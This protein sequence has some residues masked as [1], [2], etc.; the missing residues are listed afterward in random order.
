MIVA[1][2]EES[3]SNMKAIPMN[4]E[5]VGVQIR[6]P[7]LGPY[8]VVFG[9]TELHRKPEN[10]SSLAS[11]RP[12]SRFLH[13][14]HV[15]INRFLSESRAAVP[16]EERNKVWE[17]MRFMYEAKDAADE[18]PRLKYLFMHDR[19]GLL[20]KVHQQCSYSEPVPVEDNHLTCCLGVKCRECPMLQAIEKMDRPDDEKDFAK[21]MTCVT[22]IIGQGGDGMSEGY[23]MTVDDQMFWKNVCDSMKQ[24]LEECP[25]LNAI[26]CGAATCV[27]GRGN[28]AGPSASSGAVQRD[29]GDSC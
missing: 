7:D 8:N 12:G 5:Q 22:H 4:E 13:E 20:P 26:W 9:P 23:V 1:I 28:V 16:M 2:Q 24:G 10:N 17:E 18:L 29:T 15:Q 14:W 21:A 25:R 19:R 3:T 27:A 6:F 11:R